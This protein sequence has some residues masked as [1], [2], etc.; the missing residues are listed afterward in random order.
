MTSENVLVYIIFGYIRNLNRQI[1][2]IARYQAANDVFGEIL[3]HPSNGE[4]FTWNTDTGRVK[5]SILTSEC[6]QIDAVWKNHKLV[7][8]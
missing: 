5:F 1:G 7:F 4:M 8:R 6:K 3:S 2:L